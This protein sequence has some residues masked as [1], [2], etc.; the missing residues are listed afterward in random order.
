MKKFI[1]HIKRQDYFRNV[2]FSAITSLCLCFVLYDIFWPIFTYSNLNDFYVGTTIY[3]NRN[4]W[5]PILLFVF[6]IVSFYV[7]FFF[8]KIKYTKFKLNIEKYKTHILVFLGIIFVLFF[9]SYILNFSLPNVPDKHHYGEK[10]AAY[11]VHAKFHMKYYSDIMLVHGYS[12]ILPAWFAD[13][14]LGELTFFN[15]RLATFLFDFLFLCINIFLSVLIFKKEYLTI[16]VAANIFT[17]IHPMPFAAHFITIALFFVFLIQYFDKLKPFLWFSLYF[18]GATFLAMYQ[19]TIGISCFVASLPILVLQIKNNKRIGLLLLVIYS[20]LIYYLLG[21]DIAAFLDKAKYYAASN[22]YSFGNNFLSTFNIYEFIIGSYEFIIGAFA[23][24]AFPVLL[25]KFFIIKDE[26]VKLTILFTLITTISIAN[27]AFGR[28][29]EENYI[30]RAMNWS[31]AVL[32]VI[33]PYITYKQKKEY[34]FIINIAILA[35][36]IV[37]CNMVLPISWRNFLA[38]PVHSPKTY[39]NMVEKNDYYTYIQNMTSDNDLYLDLN[40]AGM[41][42][43]YADRKPAMPYTSFYNIVNSAQTEEILENLKK[44]PPKIVFLYAPGLFV[45]HDCISITQ[46][47]NK[48][49]RW[50]FLSGL[51]EFVYYKGGYFLIYNPDKENKIQISK[52]DIIA[53]GS[54]RYLPDAWGASINNLPMTPVDADLLVD[55][56]NIKVKNGVSP[57][58]ADLLYIE[59]ESESKISV[60]IYINSHLPKLSVCSKKSKMLIPLDNFPSWLLTDKIYNIRLEP[61]SPIKIKDVRLFKRL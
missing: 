13:K 51:Y 28:I 49:Y 44:N 54:L 30:P 21:A 1:E 9:V 10:F 14:V 53:Q 27:Y 56:Y 57:S 41:N 15:E 31:L 40:N 59:Y 29:D 52:A 12:D 58:N 45:G 7:V 26:K 24:L 42:Y 48:V 17:F 32:T 60:N 33:V 19:T 37:F 2:F 23:F 55:G 25:Y 39:T 34:L 20:F 46:R 4:K 8:N 6:Y 50:L 35:A 11:F 5:L 38:I 3:D 36:L 18:I 47:I 43:F 22:L 16:L 61:D